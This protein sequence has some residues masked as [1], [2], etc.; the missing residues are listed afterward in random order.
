MLRTH[1]PGELVEVTVMR[2]GK[3]LTVEVRLEV[4]P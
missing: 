2:D 3:P 4:R 1:K